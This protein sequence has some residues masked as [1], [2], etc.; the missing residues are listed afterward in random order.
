MQQLVLDIQ[1][2]KDAVLIKE[3]MKKFKGVQVNS[4]SS[5][6]T[7]KEMCDRIELGIVQANA[8]KVKPWKSVKSNLLKRIKSKSA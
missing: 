5:T 1:S 2:E 7:Q 3:L 8:G 4:F 6:V